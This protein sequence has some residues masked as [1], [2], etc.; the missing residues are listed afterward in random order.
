MGRKFQDL[1]GQRFG[2]L[3]VVER[4]GLDKGRQHS[5]WLCK[6][7]CGTVKAVSSN[8]LIGGDTASCGCLAR[9]QSVERMAK[10]TGRLNYAYKHGAGL[11]RRKSRLYRIWS[12]MKT[13][14]MNAANPSYPNYGGR[15]IA[16]CAEWVHDF[17]AFQKW[18]L[19]HGYADGLSIDRIDNDGPYSPD[20]CRWATRAEQSQNR[21][22]KELW[23][24]KKK[25]TLPQSLD[26]MTGESR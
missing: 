13:R 6:C 16:I 12:G 15:G 10:R 22:P 7:D 4:L 9:E 5:V 24:R 17:K 19:S 25:T 26:S 20:N 2:R 1:T 11:N 3:V 23:I 21:R 8:N 18:A 14:C